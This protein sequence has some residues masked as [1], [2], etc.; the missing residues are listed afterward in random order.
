[1][2]AA[3]SDAELVTAL[4]SQGDNRDV[5]EL[6][7]APYR[8]ATSAPLEEV[9]VRFADG[10][11]LGLILKDLARE[12]LLGDAPA[13][14][15][16]FLYEPRREIETYRRILAPAGIGPR[17]FASVADADP[18]RHWLAIEKV[19]GVELWQIGELEVWERVAGWLAAFHASFHGRGAELLALNPHLLEHSESWYG[20]W[21]ERASAALRASADPRAGELGPALER[22]GDVAAALAA[23]PTT[24]IHGELYPANVLVV[25]E[26]RPPDV[27]PVD[28]EMAA[29]GPG[30]VDL[31]ALVEGWGAIERDRLVAAYRAGLAAGGAPVPDGD[32]LGADLLRCR[33]HLAL[34]WLGWAPDWRP[35]AEHAHDWLDKAL[36]LARELDLL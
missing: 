7:R 8:Y 11:E 15:P 12:R 6:R 14:K 10:E 1:M 32:S 34:Q 16:E 5:A 33:L 30:L 3:P 23:M 19:P 36:S 20:S 28:W 35:P 4:R 26:A 2:T 25:R 9:S 13:A 31:A 18:P 17:L 22:Y 24:L 29:V 21:R 27:R